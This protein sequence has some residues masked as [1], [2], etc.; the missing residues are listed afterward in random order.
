MDNVKGT[1]TK[2]NL[3]YWS[4]RAK[5]N[6]KCSPRASDG[7][8]KLPSTG[9]KVNVRDTGMRPYAQ[10]GNPA[11]ENHPTRAYEESLKRRG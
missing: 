11:E 7:P 2:A 10:R 5:A 6:S 1:S 8:M 9:G 4:D 3:D